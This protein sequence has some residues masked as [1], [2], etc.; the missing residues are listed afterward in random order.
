M[1]PPF[2]SGL[3]LSARRRSII[4]ITLLLITLVIGT[5]GSWQAYTALELSK[6]LEQT[7]RLRTI[8]QSAN[9]SFDIEL[10]RAIET[11]RGTALMI[12]SASDLERDE[13]NNYGEG[14]IAEIPLVTSIEWQPVVLADDVL[15][16]EKEIQ[17]LNKGESRKFRIIEA[18]G[19]NFIPVR[20][21]PEYLPILFAVPEGTARIGLDMN[22]DPIRM[23]AK[24]AARELRS[25][26]ASAIFPLTDT[27]GISRTGAGFAISAPVFGVKAAPTINGPKEP[28]PYLR[29]YVEGLIHL[30]SVFQEAAFRVNSAEVDLIV[31]DKTEEPP[32]LIFEGQENLIDNA[33]AKTLIQSG[34]TDLVLTIRATTRVWDIVLHPRPKF[35]SKGQ[36]HYNQIILL[37]GLFATLLITLVL[38]WMQ[39]NR[40]LMEK[41]QAETLAAEQQAK[42]ALHDLRAA[43]A[44]LIQSEKMASLGQLVANVAHEINTP[45]GAVK[46]SGQNIADALDRALMEIPTLFQLLDQETIRLFSKLIQHTKGSAPILSSREERTLRAE[47]TAQLTQA[48]VLHPGFKAN[49]IVH[50]RA[51]HVVM[52]FL[53]ILNHAESTMILNTAQ[54]IGTIINN[55]ENINLAVSRVSQFVAALKSFSRKDTTHT[56]IEANL[57]DGLET[58]LTIYQ[59]QIKQRAELVRQYGLVPKMYCLP[60]ELNQVWT[61]LIHNSLQ[62]MKNFGTLTISLSATDRYAVVSVGDT[63]CGIPQALLERI[64]DPF[65]TTKAIGEGSGLGL[66]I[67]KSIVDK[68]KGHIKVQSEVDV[69]TTFTVYLP[70]KVPVA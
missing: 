29:G 15:S 57:S 24:N 31:F 8:G 19:A 35:Y 30:E 38:L 69:G 68:H 58:V 56:M 20:P 41:T 52:D 40:H 48:G 4:D 12:T 65:F 10:N 44:K 7:D 46:A 61:N 2:L 37:S 54:G 27:N 33:T 18:D 47:V 70:L 36:S 59:S 66:D 60:D 26:V 63:G 42:Q 55:A 23:A 21:R 67:A 3:K 16:F 28:I 6:K 17:T 62:A 39:R 51:Q 50:L 25:P 11:V 43:H 53:P 32:K 49:I 5:L 22:T 45:I 14:L 13:F 9:D 34:P 1:L 64:F